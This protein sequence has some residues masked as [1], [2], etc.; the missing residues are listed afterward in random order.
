M[1]KI[2]LFNL[3]ILLSFASV[4][5]LEINPGGN[6]SLIDFSGFDGSGFDP[7]PSSGQLD[8]DTWST[9]GFSGSGTN[10]AFGGSCSS[11][12]CAR[13]SSSGG[14]TTGGV[15]AFDTGSG[16]IAF[17]VQPGGSDFTPG[18]FTLKVTNNSGGGIQQFQLSY[19]IFTFNDQSRANSLNLAVS[20]DDVTYNAVPSFDFTTPGAAD[21]APVAWG[22]TNRVGMVSLPAEV[23]DGGMFFIRWGGDDESGSGS[24]DEYAIDN[25]QILNAV[26][27]VEL[28]QFTATP[29]SENEVTLSWTTASEEENDYFQ[30][31]KSRDGQ[32]F[33]A[34]GKVKGAGNS[35]EQRTY[36]FVDDA[37]KAGVNYYR[38]AQFDYNGTMEYHQVIAVAMKSKDAKVKIYPT[39]VN[40]ELNVN[41]EGEATVSIMNISG[42]LV[43][44]IQIFN[45]ATLDVSDLM[46]GTYF[47]VIKG[48]SFVEALR[49]VKQ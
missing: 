37:A 6:S 8:S 32:K 19:D 7:S 28:M 14:V 23:S 43:K 45:F 4:A 41:L 9:E 49:M 13:G 16:N 18:D 2:L 40:D 27:P 44:E 11:N 42:A 33:E 36:Q 22:S 10:V 29:I 5:Q 25:I 21:S 30:I 47:L 38:L 26:L 15:Y 34:I 35:L 17:G 24:R 48:E 39:L 1:K 46:T 31:E 20:L 3:S 12:D